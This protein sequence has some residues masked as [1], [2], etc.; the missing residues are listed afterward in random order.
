MTGEGVKD[1][2]RGRGRISELADPAEFDEVALEVE[3]LRVGFANLV[4]K[5][6]LGAEAVDRQAAVQER[7]PQDPGVVMAGGV[8][9][10]ERRPPAFEVRPPELGAEH[11]R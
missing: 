11:P 5:R 2:G 10:H 9:G 8:V 1:D 4:G 3:Q 6:D 7:G